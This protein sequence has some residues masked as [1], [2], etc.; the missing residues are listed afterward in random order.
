MSQP[1]GCCAGIEMVTPESEANRPG[2]SAIAYRLG[3]HATFLESMLARLSNLVL[4]AP[5][6]DGSG[7]LIAVRPLAHLTTRDPSDPSI[8]LLDAWATVA[9]VLT[10]YQERIANEGY[11][12]TATERRSILELARL[13]GYKLRPGVSA[14][15]F[16][17]FTVANGFKGTIPAGT[18][19]QSIPGSGE[20]PQFFETS[21]DLAARDVW[22]GL[23]PR[24]TR[25][26]IITLAAYPVTNQPA[27]INHG[28]DATTRDTLYF[29]GISTNLKAGD[30]LL[31]V[32]G[33]DPGQQVLRFVQSV[34]MQAD[35]NRTEVTLQQP[36][37]TVQQTAEMLQL[38]LQLLT[39]LVADASNIFPGSVLARQVADILKEQLLKDGPSAS[40]VEAVIPQIRIKRDVAAKRRFTRLEPWISHILDVLAWLAQNLLSL[41]VTGPAGSITGAAV[42]GPIAALAEDVPSALG[43]LFAIRDQLALPPSLQPASPLRLARSVEQ[44]FFPQADTAP[45][46]V[47]AFKPALAGTLYKA[48][49]GI[50]VAPSQIQVFAMQVKASLFG[51]NAP[52][53]IQLDLDGKITGVN[54][55]PVVTVSSAEPIWH[56][57]S[58]IVSLDSSYDKIIP[59]SWIVVQ[60]PKTNITDKQT[61]YAKAVN[62]TVLSRGDYGMSGNTTKIELGCLPNPTDPSRDLKWFNQSTPPAKVTPHNLPPND[63]FQAIR[64]TVVYAQP[65]ELELAEEPLDRDVG[66]DTI[67]LGGLYDGLESGRWIIV[68]GDRTDIPDTTGVK[69]NELA[70]IAAVTQG[71]PRD[72]W[73]W[74]ITNTA[75]AQDTLH[76]TVVLP[77]SLAYTYD[78]ATVTIYAN[79]AKA[80]HG[81]TV[82]EVLGNGDGS[83]ALQKFTLSHSPLTYLA[84]P[85]PAGAQST[86]TVRV[87]DV[88]WHE[89][90]NLAALAPRDRSYITQADNV[91]KTSTIFGNGEHGARLPTGLANV[92]AAYR[93]GIG[94]AG[95]VAA[96]QIS[97]LATRPLGAKDVINPLR[98]SGGADADSR[99]QARRNAP[100][101][102]EALD[103][104]VSVEDY[105]DFARTFAGIG[106]A[107]SARLSDVRKLVVHVTI[108]GVDDIPIDPSTDLFVSLV[109]ALHQNGDPYQPIQVDVR[110]LELLVISAGVK[111]LPDY[112]WESV[113]PK[114]RAALLNT[115]GFDQRDLG[116]SAFL[117]EAVSVVQAVEG[118]SY[119]KFETFDAVSEDVTAAE[120]AGLA[121]TLKRQDVVEADLARVD[122]NQIDPTKRIV[123]AELAILTPDIPDT[124]ILNL[125]SN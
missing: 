105:A 75:S 19:A 85:T 123:P 114:V 11:L 80:T 110:K 44:A 29:K 108:A 58:N 88:E 94:K 52:L 81:Q 116:Q 91:G 50:E 1:C 34:D 111:V 15:V 38:M 62:P 2:L 87:N 84:A 101:A 14:S 53:Q 3:T 69:G 56:E 112:Q 61:L 12:P 93:Y 21:Y 103:R 66:G 32:A 13:I 76:T 28:T 16:L 20:M 98:A 23:K 77:N 37:T 99:D 60:T 117:S 109:Q 25:P 107:S 35:Q 17:A 63:D 83:Q 67:E 68:S 73:A 47:A 24:L 55:W 26:Q 36:A 22:N 64:E 5:P 4:E 78:A 74:R 40:K 18:R 97:Q 118:V 79:V 92:K 124:L 89:S 120:L 9:D 42:A 31:I 72:V 90:D 96:E 7:N 65:V 30:A 8:A 41:D 46:L 49:T 57:S 106:K 102:V 10:F 70:M 95:N 119:T 122:A 48:W 27:A 45:R 86:L 51:H 59:N 104:L 39:A 82:G 113:E 71:P 33:N 100:L 121:R 125:I 115:F 54:D 6:P 43:N